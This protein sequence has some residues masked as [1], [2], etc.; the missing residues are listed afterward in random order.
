MINVSQ[1]IKNPVGR[2]VV[3]IPESIVNAPARGLKAGYTTGADIRTGDIKK[4]RV[5]ASDV[6]SIANPLLAAALLKSGVKVGKSIGK[7][8][9]KQ[10]LGEGA[11]TGAKYGAGFGALQGLE[12]GRN[13]S[14]LGDYTKNLLFSTGTGAAGGALL[15]AG[16][17]GLSKGAVELNKVYKKYAVPEA[18]FAKFNA[19]VGGETPTTKVPQPT[20]PPRTVLPESNMPKVSPQVVSSKPILPVYKRL[21]NAQKTLG[22][23]TVSNQMNAEV[24][25]NA[26]SMLGKNAIK[27]INLLKRV[28]GK[29]KF[30]SGDIETYRKEYPKITENVVQAIREDPRYTNL[31]DSDA[32]HVALELPTQQMARVKAADTSKVKILTREQALEK[33]AW[34]RTY[35]RPATEAEQMQSIKEW[36][37]ALNDEV[38]GIKRTSGAVSVEPSFRTKTKIA[39]KEYAVAENEANKLRIAADNAL[40]GERRTPKQALNDL[41]KAM[42]TSTNRGVLRNADGWKDK[43]RFSYARETMERNFEDIMGKDAPELK[44]KLLEPIYKAEADRTKFLNKERADIKSLGIAPRSNDSKLLQEL[45]EGTIAESQLRRQTASADKVIAAEK[46]LRQ[47]YDQYLTKLNNV[48]TRNGYAPIPKRKDYFHHFEDL[49]GAFEQVGVAIKAQ[50]LPTDI[51]GLSADFKPGKTFFSAALRRKGNKTSV[52][53]ITG[54]DKYLDGAS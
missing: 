31:S 37:K 53:A 27:D 43:S 44:R 34:D 50:D 10:V 41:A 24:A 45:G 9:F 42:E 52:D 30:A 14:N 51:N 49:N 6:A 5:L 20:I 18:G 8:T 7:Q 28:S 48:L 21:E 26:R 2:F 38:M 16:T 19:K 17:A 39:N 25:Q 23:Q 13:I 11:K 15:G 29:Q 32:L 35:G 22:E 54:I 1:K 3:S 4:P 12:S 46:V 40:Y 36:E 33:Q 47:K